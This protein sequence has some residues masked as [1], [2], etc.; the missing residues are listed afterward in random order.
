MKTQNY[1]VSKSKSEVFESDQKQHNGARYSPCGKFLVAGGYEGSIYRWDVS[2]SSIDLLEEK[3]KTLES[4]T[5]HKEWVQALA[6]SSKTLFS[7]DSHGRLMA[8]DYKK[9]KPTNI[10]YIENAH[11]GWIRN[12]VVNKDE[13]LLATCGIDK[14]IRVWSTD[15]GKKIH[16]F[17]DH[18]KDVLSL[19]FHPDGEA[20]FLIRLFRKVTSLRSRTLTSFF[21]T[22]PNSWQILFARS[23]QTWILVRPSTMW[24]STIK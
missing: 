22:K 12:I 7:G 20:R 19:A 11:D 21:T 10:W 17:K 9:E 24:T 5:G 16:E 15:D 3:P 23:L 8:W 1:K 4:L 13:K 6:F 2:L 14:V 18:N